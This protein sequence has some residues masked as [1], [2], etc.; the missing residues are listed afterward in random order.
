MQLAYPILMLVLVALSG[1]CARSSQI[2]GQAS[3]LDGDT[4]E[5]HGERIRM[6]GI[7]APE[8][9]QRCL[10]AQGVAWRCGQRASLALDEKIARR[11]VRCI[12]VGTGVYGRTLG[13]CLVDREDLQAWMVEE[14]WAVAYRKYSTRYVAQERRARRAKR[15]IWEGTFVMPWDW[16][17]GQRIEPEKQPPPPPPGCE[18]KGN[19][20]SRGERIYHKPGGQWYDRTVVRPERGHRWFCSEREAKAAGWRPAVR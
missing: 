13:R 8:S 15:G 11:P 10:D 4:L 1:G 9:G 2:V 3:V 14:G 16:R 6:D 20:N 7:D 17:R 18:I 5:I 19:I 12:K